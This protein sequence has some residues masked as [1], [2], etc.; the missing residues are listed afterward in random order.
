MR[1]LMKRQPAL[2][3]HL[4]RTLSPLSART[5]EMM[6]MSGV[7]RRADSNPPLIPPGTGHQAPQNPHGASLQ[8][9]ASE[10]GWLSRMI[11]GRKPHHVGLDRS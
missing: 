7:V 2:T 5:L 10:Q 6:V 3:V 1:T 9:S 4:W 11:L 8:E